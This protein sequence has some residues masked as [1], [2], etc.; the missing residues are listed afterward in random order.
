MELFCLVSI[1]KLGPINSILLSVNSGVPKL[2]FIEIGSDISSTILKVVSFCIFAGSGFKV[3]NIN[4]CFILSLFNKI[5]IEGINI[6]LPKF[7]TNSLK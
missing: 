2:T 1:W 4:S 5:L 3:F 6:P 7:N